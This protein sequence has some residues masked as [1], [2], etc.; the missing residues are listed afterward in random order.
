MVVQKLALQASGANAVALGGMSMFPMM[1]GMGNGFALETPTKVVALTE[2]CPLS[3]PLTN[4]TSLHIVHCS[5]F[6]CH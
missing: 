1:A 6:L 2:V 3:S 5:E 4:L